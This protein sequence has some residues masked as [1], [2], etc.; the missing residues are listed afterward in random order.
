MTVDLK[1]A[2]ASLRD[3]LRD[4]V[5]H[6]PTDGSPLFEVTA[7]EIELSVALTSGGQ[8]GVEIN[9]TIIP[10]IL[11]GKVTAGA[12]IE[13]ATT[14]K[15]KLSLKPPPDT[16]VSREGID[17]KDTTLGVKGAPRRRRPRI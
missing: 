16:N 10:T 8:G 9:W 13:Q 15:L 7:I 3:Q 5:Q 12:K 6:Q 14:H 4:A 17:E 2:I 11:S 1:T